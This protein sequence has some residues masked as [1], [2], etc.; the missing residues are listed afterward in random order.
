MCVQVASSNDRTK[1]T[2]TQRMLGKVAV[3]RLMPGRAGAGGC[4]R[5]RGAVC[6]A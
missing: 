5:G 6:N 1:D 3:K 2:K 4:W